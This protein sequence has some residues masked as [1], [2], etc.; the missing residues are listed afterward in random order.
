LAIWLP[1]EGKNQFKKDIFNYLQ[2]LG[3]SGLETQ[4]RRERN[5]MNWTVLEYNLLGEERGQ[6]IF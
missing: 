4:S 3:E 5:Q 2:H 1:L 6:F